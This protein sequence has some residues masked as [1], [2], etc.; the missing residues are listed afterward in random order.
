MR[1]IRRSGKR[2][3]RT[4]RK[5]TI[6][7]SSRCE[8]QLLIKKVRLKTSS[9]RGENWTCRVRPMKPDSERRRER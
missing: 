8:K 3:I 9:S 6:S 7:R 1:G 5:S 2:E 4:I